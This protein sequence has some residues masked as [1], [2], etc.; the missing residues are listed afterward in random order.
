MPNTQRRSLAGLAAG[1]LT[2]AAL[3]QPIFLLGST[4]RTVLDAN[5]GTTE[6]FSIDQHGNT[7]LPGEY[8]SV[9]YR[10][11]PASGRGLHVQRYNSAMAPIPFAANGEALFVPPGTDDITGYSVET[12]ANGDLIV[13]GEC[14]D[15]FSGSGLLNTFV[16]RMSRD[17]QTVFWFVLIRGDLFHY[18]SVTAR[19][20]ADGTIVVTHNAGV[21]NGDLV[22]GVA[23]MSRLTPAGNLIW[24][25][26]YSV[27]N[28]PL[29]RIWLA[30]V[31]Q[32]PATRN[33]WAAGYVAPFINSNA[34]LLNVDLQTGCPEGEGGYVYPHPL[35]ENTAY[36]AIH[37]DQ[38]PQS[39]Y[40]TMVAAGTG[41]SNDF[42]APIYPRI[43]D[44]PAG[45]GCYNWDQAYEVELATAPT[46]LSIRR[47][48]YATGIGRITIAGAKS[49]VFSGTTPARTLEVD[50]NAGGA[51]IACHEY[52]NGQKTWFNDISS[53]AVMMLGG[54]HSDVN[55]DGAVDAL[56][57]FELYTVG[58]GASDC[59]RKLLAPELGSGDC[60]FF[61]PDCQFEERRLELQLMPV[62]TVG[63]GTVICKWTL[64]DPISAVGV[65]ISFP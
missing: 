38:R 13:A 14:R 53:P 35:F 65:A 4:E 5:G 49:A 10:T 57:P 59:A 19:E 11:L 55:G 1:L 50:A 56:D 17:L 21:P 9:G 24:T 43:T 60:T 44:V 8:V 34:L 27:P 41:W 31:R 61:F 58:R 28:N 12:A 15:D 25:R 33:L 64:P 54:R 48:S 30:D 40:Y 22:Q 47:A 45:G 2:A 39:P 23:L 46:A 36:D 26:I 52:G 62:D 6:H 20:L 37:I 63:Y 3:A 7:A 16:C 51:V 42:S 29:G 32:D 18:P